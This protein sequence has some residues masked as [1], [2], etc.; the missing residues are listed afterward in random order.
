MVETFW[1]L[2]VCPLL[3]IQVRLH[4]IGVGSHLTRLWIHIRKSRSFFPLLYTPCSEHDE[5]KRKRAIENHVVIMV[6]LP[7]KSKGCHTCRR[8]KVRVRHPEIPLPECDTDIQ[9]SATFSDQVVRDVSR[10][11]EPVKA[12]N[13]IPYFS[14]ELLKA[15]REGTDYRKRYLLLLRR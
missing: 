9:V 10:A 1:F 2:D 3:V 6:G 14:I 11:V 4:G 5:Y 13:A 15:C 7:G 8:R 12:T